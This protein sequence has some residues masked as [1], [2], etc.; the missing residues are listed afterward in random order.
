MIISTANIAQQAKLK[1]TS[2]F[3]WV[4]MHVCVYMRLHVC[5]YVVYNLWYRI[6]RICKI[7]VASFC[8]RVMASTIPSQRVKGENGLLTFVILSFEEGSLFRIHRPNN[9][10]NSPLLPNYV[11]FNELNCW[12]WQKIFNHKL[13]A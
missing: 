11:L 12:G 2:V 4:C 7:S 6:Y 13:T 1:K 8:S 10:I 5:L 9:R 3:V